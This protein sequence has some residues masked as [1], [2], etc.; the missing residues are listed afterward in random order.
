M[1]KLTITR[2][3]VPSLLAVMGCWVLFVSTFTIHELLLGTG[4]TILTVAV[5][6]LAWSEM[7][8]HFWPTPEQVAQTWRVPWYILH[9]SF[10][11]TWVLLRDLA[12]TRH[13]GSLYRAAPFHAGHGT[14]REARAIL[15][16]TATTMTPSIIVLGVSK[17]RIFLHQLECSPIPGMVKKLEAKQ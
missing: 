12:G 17:D 8:I 6:Y 7:K 14:R 11:V 1:R 16:I 2:A 3:I 10:E 13:A 5:S 9:D 15:A 4:F